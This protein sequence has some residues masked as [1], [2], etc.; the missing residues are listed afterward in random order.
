[1]SGVVQT[2]LLL[3]VLTCASLANEGI[4]Q[5]IVSDVQANTAQSASPSARIIGAHRLDDTTIR[6]KEF[7][8]DNWHTTWASD[9]H[10]YVLQCDGRG[11]NTRLW[12][13][14]ATHRTSPSRPWPRTRGL[15]SRTPKPRR[16]VPL[17]RF[18][19]RRGGRHLLPL[20]LDTEYLVHATVQ[21][22]RCQ[23]RLLPRRWCDLA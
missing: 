23:T 22:R 6:R 15:R 5:P 21:V 17:L 3:T 9:G 4:S 10:Q 13:L 14:R 18:R 1:M 12:R 2:S 16:A 11:Y 8:G 19:H 20:L 7:T